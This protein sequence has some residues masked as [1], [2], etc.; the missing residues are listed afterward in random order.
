VKPLQSVSGARGKLKGR[1]RSRGEK[2]PGVSEAPWKTRGEKKED[3][4]WT[5]SG[6]KERKESTLKKNE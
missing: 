6:M 5:R 3:L 2:G 1:D 4:S